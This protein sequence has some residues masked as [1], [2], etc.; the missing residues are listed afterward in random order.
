[1]IAKHFPMRSLGKSDFAGLTSYLTDEQGK[2][3][4]LGAVQ[5]SNCHAGDVQGAVAE[6]LATQHLN[7][8]AKGDKTYHLM[9]G[10]PP[11]E[12][13]S[14]E[15][16]KDIEDRLC[17]SL[18]YG[19]HQRISVV[20][21]DT[22]H[23]HVH[24]AINKI[25]P[26]RHT[27]HEPYLAYKT[28]GSMCSVLEKEHG[29]QIV[30]HASKKTLS[31]GKAQDMEQHSGIESM[32]SWMRR[33]CVPGLM[34]AKS[35]DDFNQTL[36]QHGLSAQAKGNGIV[37]CSSDGIAVK[38]SSVHRDLSK[39]KLESRF[40]AFCPEPST[41][42]SPQTQYTKKPMK[43]GL[44]TTELFAQYQSEMKSLAHH[45][46]KVLAQLRGQKAENIE[47]AK[48]GSRLRRAAIR[49]MKGNPLIKKIL[50]AQANAALKEQITKINKQFMKDR[51][52]LFNGARHRAWADWL[53][54]KAVSGDQHAL[55]ALRAREANRAKQGLGATGET[56]THQ[57]PLQMDTITKRGT[58]IYRAG[59]AAV[60]D[61]GNKI[62]VSRE[63]NHQ[64]IYAA[65][66]ATAERYGT[67][68]TVT[69][70]DEFREKLITVAA[71]SRLQITFSDPVLETKRQE[72]I[73]ELLNGRTRESDEQRRL[74]RSSVGGAGSAV[75]NDNRAR[76][77]ERGERTGRGGRTT[78]GAA[79]LERS[80][81]QSNVGRIGRVPPPDRKNRLRKL[82][83]CGMVRIASRSEV[84]LQSHVPS[85]MEQSRAAAADAMR[86]SI[87]RARPVIP[88]LS[89]AEK[90]ISEREQKRENGFDIP[91]HRGYNVSDTGEASLAG[92]RHIDGQGLAL[93]RKGEEIVVMP[94][95]AATTRRMERLS[96]GST[97]TVTDSG[98][99]RAKGRS[100]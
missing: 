84:L 25:H 65:L 88:P 6:V 4:R 57:N 23:M 3:E 93:L 46:T 39:K 41:D 42:K 54:H 63:T 40:G 37:F 91:K 64:A 11:G 51:Q 18:G 79:G 98:T 32:I 73:K 56:A 22:D 15:V 70:S 90:Y 80:S 59:K 50:Y 47:S 24:I 61:D 58:I 7:T 78:T 16:L 97:V 2:T 29:L 17:K 5:I 20:H 53:R 89:P 44:D 69:G 92:V 81:I 94:I 21:H 30:N 19:E 31:E 13:P 76:T 75:A 35:W 27:L 49:L 71:V 52:E 67:K 43:S 62:S 26:E 77:D 33:E 86:R 48:Q 34:E 72:K 38:A 45:K 100:R 85:N 96:V 87:S 66:K 55:K 36:K 9:V 74:D 82:S 8:R 60:R 1:M 14:A 95:D 68:I 28:L 99:L 12:T 10:F 83:S